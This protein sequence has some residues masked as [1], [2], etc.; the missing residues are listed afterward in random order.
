MLPSMTASFNPLT[1]GA[2]IVGTLYTRAWVHSG[3]RFQSPDQWGGYC[4]DPKVLS[5]K[6]TPREFQS[7]DQWGGYCGVSVR[8][9]KSNVALGSFN[10]L[11]N[12]AD[13]V[14]HC[15]SWVSVAYAPEVSI[16]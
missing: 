10:P 7:P 5:P 8:R 15:Y 12:G 16:P 11:T 13:I 6:F 2:D 14:G 3:L 4:G 9:R 1:N